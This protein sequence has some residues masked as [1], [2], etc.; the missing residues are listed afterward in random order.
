[1]SVSRYAFAPDELEA[2]YR[3]IFG[4]RDTRSYRPEPLPQGLVWKILGAAHAAPSVGFMQPWN[5]ILIQDTTRRT[6][7]LEHFTRVSKRAAE[8][9]QDARNL[10]YRALKLQ[11]ILDAPLNLLVTCD[12]GRDG[13][14]VLGRSVQRDTDVYSTCLAIQNLWLAAR[15]EGLGMGWVS[16]FEPQALADLLGMP[17]GSK[18][19]AVLCLG[20][21][22]AFYDAPM[23]VQQGWVEPR[24]LSVLLFENQWGTP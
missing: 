14:H 21:V 12:R 4:R 17:A 11:G 5:F 6:A 1:M 15:A 18:P 3:A 23:L 24:P 8:D 10:R 9:F 20:P 13:P 7:L 2:V 19:L 22:T 16:L